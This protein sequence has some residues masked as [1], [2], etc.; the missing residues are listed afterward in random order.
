MKSF[1]MSMWKGR[2]KCWKV[3][4]LHFYGS[5]LIDIMT[6]KV[7]KFPGTDGNR[8][9][10][11]SFLALKGLVKQTTSH[12][13]R[14]SAKHQPENCSMQCVVDTYVY[15]NAKKK[16][17]RPLT[18]IEPTCNHQHLW[19]MFVIRLCGSTLVCLSTVCVCVCVCVCVYIHVWVKHADV[20]L[21]TVY[22]IHSVAA[23][24]L[25]DCKSLNKS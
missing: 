9:T 24:S 2:Q 18:R 23:V 10:I 6:V 4:I 21:S 25:C 13:G 22:S 15:Q 17:S 8:L 3:K 1:H 20:N 12:C 16:N 11:S 7:L 5:F 14:K 19:E